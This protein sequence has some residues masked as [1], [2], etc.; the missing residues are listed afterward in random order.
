M[1]KVKYKMK[2]FGGA[3]GIKSK[4][5]RSFDRDQIIEAEEG[6]FDESLAELVKE[7]KVVKE[8]LK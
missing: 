4:T 7:E 2:S 5:F 8:K 6:E 3:H 1:K